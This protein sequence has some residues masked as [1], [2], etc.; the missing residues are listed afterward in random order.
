VLAEKEK[1]PFK[2]LENNLY[3][4]K[5]AGFIEK[6]RGKDGE[7]LLARPS[8]DITVGEIIQALEGPTAPTWCT[9]NPGIAPAPARNQKAAASASSCTTSPRPPP[10][11]SPRSRLPTWPALG[12]PAKVRRKR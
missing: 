12:Y 11:S 3:E 6:L 7:A 10:A 1:L 4:L 8:H 5:Q 2:H 9:G